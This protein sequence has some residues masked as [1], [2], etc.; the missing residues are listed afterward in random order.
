MADTWITNLR[1]YLDE[2]GRLP[3]ELPGPARNLANHLGSIVTG[4]T[5]AAWPAPQQLAV[6]CR[7]RPRNRRCSGSIVAAIE[8]G[9]DDI[10]W[11]CP[12]CGDNGVVS[13]WQGTVWDKSKHDDAPTTPPGYEHLNI[14]SVHDFDARS[15]AREFVR[16][17]AVAVDDISENLYDL[18]RDELFDELGHAADA[19]EIRTQRVPT[20][21]GPVFVFRDPARVSA[22]QA[23]ALVLAE[24]QWTR[25]APGP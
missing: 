24:Y 15:A 21:I 7:R 1:H 20:S 25:E 9:S 8:P 13:G 16:L 10:I 5:A 14:H 22:T 12:A 17:G 3:D 11:E 18:A 2:D 6:G 23:K 4:I 19:F